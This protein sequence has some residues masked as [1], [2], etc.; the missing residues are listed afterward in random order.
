MMNLNLPRL[1]QPISPG[2]SPGSLPP[3]ERVEFDAN[4]G[5]YVLVPVNRGR[6][7]AKISPTDYR[8]LKAAGWLS[9]WYVNSNGNGSVYVRANLATRAEAKTTIARLILEA[10][11]DDVVRYHRN[12]RLDLRRS[13]LYL[14]DRDDHVEPY[15]RPS[16]SEER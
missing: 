4:H 5:A 3:A 6:H 11:P 8:R 7:H 2:R 15:R 10:S 9:G 14:K 1:N 12:D 13:N 16:S